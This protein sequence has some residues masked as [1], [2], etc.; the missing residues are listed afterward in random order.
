MRV[1]LVE[2]ERD[3]ANAIA[4]GLRSDGLAVDLAFDGAE[5]LEKAAVHPYDVVVLD[6]DLP[7]V[8]GDDV[9]RELV[10]GDQDCRILMLTAAAAVHD[11]IEGLDL[12]ADDYLAKPFDFGELRARLRALGRRARPAAQPVLERDGV[13]LDAARRSAA[14]DGRDLGL[15]RK[16]FAVLQVLLEAEGAVVSPEEL[17][18]RAW[19][20]HTDP[21]T[22]VVRVTIMKL[23]KSLGEPPLI[24]TVRGVGYR[25]P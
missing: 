2:D 21:F 12:G 22:N 17:L 8:H 24:E 15:T 5:A 3:L 9:C 13:R 6:R 1:L 20:E 4:R 19:D 7:A 25:I 11:R 16:E 10:A 18:D 14:R 23:R